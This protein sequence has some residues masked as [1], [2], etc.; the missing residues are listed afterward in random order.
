M[1]FCSGEEGTSDAEHIT[2]KVGLAKGHWINVS[3]QVQTPSKAFSWGDTIT[4]VCSPDPPGT[5][6][7]GQ[8]RRNWWI[9]KATGS[10]LSFVFPIRGPQCGCVAG[11]NNIKHERLSSLWAFMAS[12]SIW[13]VF[14][15]WAS[16]PLGLQTCLGEAFLRPSCRECKIRGKAGELW[17]TERSSVSVRCHCPDVWGA[18]RGR[19]GGK[20][21]G[22]DWWGSERY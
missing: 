11:D 2:V 5:R 8:K 6:F 15:G 9:E 18:G 16:C 19:G 3:E 22:W 1:P 4:A 17:Q 10:H 13:N 21:P 12:V 14:H 20:C 7:E